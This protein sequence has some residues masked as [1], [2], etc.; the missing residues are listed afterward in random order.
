MKDFFRCEEC[1]DLLTDYL[2]GSLD[3]EVKDK[4]DEHLAGCAPCINFV[5]TFERSADLTHRLREQQV[6]VPL[7]VQQRLK[8]FLKQEIVTLAQGSEEE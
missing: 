3:S 6:D 1:V 7:E 5:N 4:L 8:S 2:E